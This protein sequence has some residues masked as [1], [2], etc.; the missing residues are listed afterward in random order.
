VRAIAVFSLLVIGCGGGGGEAAQ[1]VIPAPLPGAPSVFVNWEN[2]PVHA[3]EVTPDG[4]LLLVCNGPDARLEV[5][6]LSGGV[7]ALLASVP[8]GLDPV[9][10]RARSNGEAWVVN[11]V[12]DSVSVVDL[13]ARRL[14]ATLRTLDEP[15]DVV[16]AGAPE[17]AYVSCSQANALQVFDPDDLDA[18]P[19]TIAIE[20]EDPRALAVSADGSEVYVAIFESGNATTLLG[21]GLDPDSTLEDGF[22]PNV[23]SDPDGP[24]GGVNPPPND[25]ASFDPPQR[26]GNPEPPG[27]G[28]VVRRGGDGLWRDD[29]GADWTPFVSGP[30]A[31]RS[32]RRPGWDLLDRDVAILDTATGDVRY[33]SDSCLNVCMAIAVQ[34]GTGRVTAV[35]TEATN[36]VRFEPILN[37]RFVRVRMG[38]F[39]PAPG[40]EAE[41]QDLNPHLDYAT[42]TVPEAER[43]RSLGDP[44]GVAWNA[45]GTRAWVTGMGSNNVVVLDGSLDR[46]G[47][48]EVGEGPTGIALAGG[49]AYVLNRFES[50][51]SVIDTGALAEV[52]RVPLHDPTPPATR[53][54]RR[55]LYGTHE[56]S[57]L[58]HV[59]CASCH[60]DARMDRLA[61]DLGDPAGEVKPLD[62]NCLTDVV[63][64]CED[65]HPMKGPMLTQTLLDIVGKEPFH[66]R[67]DRDGLEEFNGAFVSLL[68]D[69]TTLTAAEMQAFEDFLAGLH[70]PPNPFRDFDNS[71]PGDVPLPGHFSPGRFGPAGEPLPDGNAR[72]GLGLYRTANLDGG[73]PGFQCVT[74][75]TLP[76]GIG[77]DVTLSAN[78]IELVPPGPD[79]ERHHS[80]VSV[81]GSTNVSIKIPQLR[82]LYDRVGFETS[83]PTSRAGFGFLHDGSVDS[84]ARFVAEPV[85]NV[86]SRQ[87]IADLV[88]FLLA[89]SGSD[90]PTGSLD[91]LIELPGPSSRDTHAAVGRQV[92]F[93]ARR[94]DALL[95]AMLEL[96]AAGAVEL[97]AKGQGR[98]WWYDAMRELFQ[99]DRNEESIAFDDLHARAAPDLEITFTVVPL[100]CGRRMGVDRDND[101]FGDR[102]EA[103]FGTDPADAADFPR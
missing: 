14:T 65:F 46:V 35:G 58:G 96:A 31:E 42:P 70:F 37:G 95:E 34:P 100:G 54:G 60:V 2:L 102:T 89:F 33:A 20:A 97:V 49:R 7:P 43:D 85:F 44:R 76:T 90:L 61:W 47:R 29:T 77:P 36:D 39:D 92:T 56:T 103:D 63:V 67:G 99:S 45:A 64:A 25:G 84:I 59:A 27:V 53:D 9:A 52:A 88:A 87:E 91:N 41:V 62:Q 18:A 11:H 26:P 8:V 38:R 15:A 22:P 12:S 69:D 5:F 86:D 3:V 73:V 74:C 68:G 10:V 79:G 17:R 21:G 78:G 93:G 1:V 28:L 4:V 71:L 30:L 101:G 48:I 72:R 50:S 98:G 94:D 19:A 75:H 66:W 51:V 82:N 57:G 13:A 83:R 80:L 81:D 40:G 23:V 24:H 55:F 16:F 32:G 6:D